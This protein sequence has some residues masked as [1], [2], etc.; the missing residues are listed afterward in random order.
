MKEEE[1]KKKGKQGREGEARG[2]GVP[3]GIMHPDSGSRNPFCEKK[4]KKKKK[5]SA[6]QL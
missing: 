6:M 2:R 3:S 1:G 5:L 4:K